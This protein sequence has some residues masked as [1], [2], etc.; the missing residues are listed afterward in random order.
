MAQPTGEGKTVLRADA[1]PART[2]DFMPLPVLEP[3]ERADWTV[4]GVAVEPADA[5]FKVTMTC[6]QIARPVEETESTHFFK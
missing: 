1:T 2:L 5:R 3:K 4:T 6:D